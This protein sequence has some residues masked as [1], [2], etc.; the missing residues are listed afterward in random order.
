MRIKRNKFPT[1]QVLLNIFFILLCICYAYPLLL[2]L[3]ISVE[4]ASGNSFSII[5]K[6]F[7]LQAYQQIFSRP[8][9]LSAPTV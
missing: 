4:G 7:T 8:E 3:T 6:D 1:G 5:V 9:K 2:L